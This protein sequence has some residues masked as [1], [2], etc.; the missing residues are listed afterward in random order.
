MATARVENSLELDDGND[1]EEPFLVDPPPLSSY[2]TDGKFWCAF[3]IY[4]LIFIYTNVVVIASWLEFDV[5]EYEY[6]KSRWSSHSSTDI[7]IELYRTNSFAMAWILLA[8]TALLMKATHL[9]EKDMDELNEEEDGGD[10][11]TSDDANTTHVYAKV[12]RKLDKFFGQNRRPTHSILVSLLYVA[13]VSCCAGSIAFG[14]LYFYFGTSS[15]EEHCSRY[16]N[17]KHNVKMIGIPEELQNWARSVEN[18]PRIW[19]GN[20]ITD[21]ERHAFI[22]MSDRRTFFVGKDM[23]NGYADEESPGMSTALVSVSNDNHLRVHSDVFSPRLFISVQGKGNEES[24][25]FCCFYETRPGDQNDGDLLS[26]RPLSVL[27][28]PH[29]TERFGSPRSDSIGE[30]NIGSLTAWITPL[31]STVWILHP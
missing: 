8:N 22:H 23:R 4:P 12:S 19:N 2:V 11:P 13:A 14:G 6:S 5:Y 24:D 29:P 3:A 7:R 20:L 16:Q 31:S 17:T 1:E 10:I 25:L 28:Q 26:L 21:A 18:S 15:A 9:L 27:V 30:S